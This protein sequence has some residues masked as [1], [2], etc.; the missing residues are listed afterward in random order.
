MVLFS[1]AMVSYYVN[2]MLPIIYFN[3]QKTMKIKSLLW[4]TQKQRKGIFERWKEYL[5]YPHLPEEE[6]T[7]KNVGRKFLERKPGF[8]FQFLPKY[9]KKI[10]F[11]G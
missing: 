3:T 6:L 8:I 4:K 1:L 2:V 10:I 9:S 5:N 11:G 7:L